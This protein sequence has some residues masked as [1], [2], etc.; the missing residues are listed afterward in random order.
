MNLTDENGVTR[1]F[2]PGEPAKANWVPVFR[3]QVFSSSDEGVSREQFPIV[4]AWALAHWKAQGMTLS[5]ARVH[6]SEKTVGV[7]GLAF[8]ASTR[9]RH[10][11]DLLFEDDLPEYEHFMKARGTPAFRRRRR[12]ELRLQER[13]SATLRKYRYCMDDQ[14]TKEEA[15]VAGSLIEPLKRIA[16]KQRETLRSPAG[17]VVDRDTWLWGQQEPCYETL[18]LDARRELELTDTDASR[19]GL[20]ES[21]VLRL[22]DRSRRRVVFFQE[23]LDVDQLMHASE[24][25]GHVFDSDDLIQQLAGNDQKLFDRFVEV[26]RLVR[27]RIDQVGRWDGMIEEPVPAPLHGELHVPAV[28]GVLGALIPAKLHERFDQAASKQKLPKDVPQGGSY[29]RCEGWR[30]SVYE[31]E[32]LLR[33]RLG[34]G[35][36]E[37]FLKSLGR[38]SSE[39]SLGVSVGTSPTVDEYC[40]V[41]RRWRECWNPVD[42]GKRQVLFLPVPL[43]DV[44]EPRDGR[45]CLGGARQ[46]QVTVYDR[47]V[48]KKVS[49]RIACYVS[50][51]FRDRAGGVDP[52]II[53]EVLPECQVAA[54]L[55]ACVLGVIVFLIQ[56]LARQ[57][58]LDRSTA[59]FVS[60]MFVVFRAVFAKLRTEFAARTLSD[61]KEYVLGE[62]SRKVLSMFG[63]VPRPRSGLVAYQGTT[64]MRS[65]QD[66][67]AVI[68]KAATWNVRG[69][70][71]SAQAPECWS[72]ADQ[73]NELVNEVLRWDCDVVALQEV[74]SEG[75][76]ERLAHCYSHVGS[77][78]S[79]RGFVQ[80][81]VSKR[82]AFLLSLVGTV[83]ELWFVVCP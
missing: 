40:S 24:Q 70:E 35:M 71:K 56:A 17:C 53:Q 73:R 22:L 3:K 49:E 4:L 83:V 34:V 45:S 60:D 58:H 54:Q 23:N 21:V 78:E 10:S 11:W 14:W 64:S 44:P 82:L 55:I 19:R 46:L 29:L 69:G 8:V 36:L 80:L 59:T 2:F 16:A 32:H 77:S 62:E 74:E 5:G 47:V 68:L 37:F 42:V 79:H 30:V 12:W 72:Q 39:M 33:G 31:E 26:A 51:L 61:I 25:T 52:V 15:D 27:R 18:L 9:V 63:E 7:A 43:A 20:Y 76:I 66:S 28:K 81:Y 6:L 41:L 67:G 13:T 57:V 50:A 38:Y 65:V 75:P 1:T 48:R